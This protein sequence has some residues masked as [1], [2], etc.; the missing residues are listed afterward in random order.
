[1]KINYLLLLKILIIEIIYVVAMFFIL[2]F[3]GYGLFCC[4]GEVSQASITYNMI[5][6]YILAVPPILFN[7]YKI[8]KLNRTQ[9]AN[10]ISYVIVEII[11]VLLFGYLIYNDMLGS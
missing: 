10:S 9:H 8:F 11:M 6:I 5:G 2:G 3:I 4:G 7:L 1:M